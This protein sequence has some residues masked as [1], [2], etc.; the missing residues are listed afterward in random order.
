MGI[1]IG[2]EISIRIRDMDALPA[3]EADARAFCIQV[4]GNECWEQIKAVRLLA[5]SG[6]AAVTRAAPINPD[7]ATRGIEVGITIKGSF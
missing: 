4:L 2:G 6:K 5:A 1:E 7:L 3:S